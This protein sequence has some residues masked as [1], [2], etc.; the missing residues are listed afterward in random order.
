MGMDGKPM[1]SLM[2]PAKSSFTIFPPSVTKFKNDLFEES[3][4]EFLL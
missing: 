3:F 2:Q 1:L 4:T